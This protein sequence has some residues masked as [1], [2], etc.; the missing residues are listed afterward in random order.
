[1]LGYT[2][3]SLE[4]ADLPILPAHMR[5]TS[6]FSR[7]RRLVKS[8]HSLS[9]LPSRAS[10]FQFTLKVPFGTY[11]T[12]RFPTIERRLPFIRSSRTFKPFRF[13]IPRHSS[14]YL[15]IQ[16]ALSN[17]RILLTE[18]GLAA[19]CAL[20]F[21]TPAFF[22]R[23]LII[24][25]ENDPRRGDVKKLAEY[26]SSIADGEQPVNTKWAWVYCAGLFGTTAIMYCEYLFRRPFGFTEDLSYCSY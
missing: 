23:K 26:V 13:N 25:L 9:L 15:L 19:V 22:F 8:R 2:A 7:M 5:A 6:I 3:T 17:K 11:L 14:S 10:D 24:W 4:T 16:L 20:V 18:V 1:M 21:Y 12:S